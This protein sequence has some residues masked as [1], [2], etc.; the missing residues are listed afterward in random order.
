[1]R[2]NLPPRGD[3]RPALP[4]RRPREALGGADRSKTQKDFVGQIVEALIHY[5]FCTM[6]Y[7]IY[8]YIYICDGCVCENE[9]LGLLRTTIVRGDS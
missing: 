1:M 6:M 8:I 2:F 5:T 7:H 3:G 4:T 9:E